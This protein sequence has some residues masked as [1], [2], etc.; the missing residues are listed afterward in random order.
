[1]ETT[2]KLTIGSIVALALVI[3][4]AIYI[5]EALKDDAFYC[6]ESGLVAVCI[7]GVKACTDD[8][9]T[10][11]YYNENN[12]RSYKVCKSGW[13]PLV[14]N[15]DF[16]VETASE[17]FVEANAERYKCPTNDGEVESYTKC[18][19]PTGKDAYF[20]ELV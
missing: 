14:E 7:N 1:M 5:P 10:R 11:C 12:T 15:P 2:T 8:V 17:V 18:V 3:S 9:C 6:E 19:S 13:L 4:G 16:K 20:G